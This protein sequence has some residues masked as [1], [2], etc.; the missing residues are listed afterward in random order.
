MYGLIM[1]HPF[2]DANKRTAFLTALLHLQ[3]IGRTPTIEGQKFEDFTVAIADHKLDQY[4]F[5]GRKGG[6]KDEMDIAAIAHFLRRNSRDID[7]KFK[8]ITYNRLKTIIGRHGLILDNQEHNRIDVIKIREEDGRVLSKP[9]RITKIGFHGWKNEVSPKDIHIL[10]LAAKLDV[11]D[12]Y[13]SQSF[14]NG[15]ESPLNLIRKY[16]EP[17]KRL[18]Y[19]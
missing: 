6:A 16:Q 17:L 3:K 15:V 5:Y 12:G 13:D 14:F 18:A 1:N 11:G 9:V 10:R 7:L 4:E 19:R 8:F 2:H